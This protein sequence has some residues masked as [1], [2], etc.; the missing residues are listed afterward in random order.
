MVKFE[1]DVFWEKNE[2]VFWPYFFPSHFHRH[3][4]IFWRGNQYKNFANGFSSIC[5]I[6][7]NKN[8]KEWRFFQYGKTEKNVNT[9]WHYLLKKW[10][11]K[12]VKSLTSEHPVLKLVTLSLP[13]C[14]TSLRLRSFGCCSVRFPDLKYLNFKD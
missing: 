7:A 2:K 13:S 11:L 14:R 6:F 12:S 4:V 5:S 3:F 10:A 1:D 8:Q 9:S